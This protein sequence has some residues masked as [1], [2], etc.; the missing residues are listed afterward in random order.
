MR[1]MN[2]VSRVSRIVV[3]CALAWLGANAAHAQVNPEGGDVAPPSTTWQPPPAQVQQSAPVVQPAPAYAPQTQAQP[4]ASYAAPQGA[5]DH[6]AQ[7]GR[8]GFGFFGVTQIPIAR[9]NNPGCGM[10]DIGETL[11]APSIGLRYWL[12]DS[13]GIDAALGLN[14]TSG[15]IAMAADESFLGV[16]L[17]GGL[18]FALAHSGH[19]V[20]EVV[21]QLNFGIASG[22]YEAAAPA[23][24]KTDVSGLLIEVGAKAGAEIHFGFIDIPQLSLQGTFGL[25]IR[26]ESRS[27][28]TAPAVPGGVAAKVEQSATMVTT[29]VDGEPW[30]IFV[31]GLTAIYYF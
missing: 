4:V 5:D 6:T 10:V 7:N 17:H 1:N 14:I 11:A 18:P 8:F 26:H 25:M 30:D 27:T 2:V 9:C 20:F 13:M 21:P 24:A 3:G 28:T 22:S 16:V 12:S 19:F 29:G 31:G 23:T 15:S